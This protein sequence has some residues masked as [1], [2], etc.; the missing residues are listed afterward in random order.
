MDA[1]CPLDGRYLNKVEELRPYFSEMAL[2][3]ERLVVSVEYLNALSELPEIAELPPFSD[4]V[5]DRLQ[6][7]AHA[8]SADDFQRVRAIE[9]KVNHDVKAGEYFLREKITEH[10]LPIPLQFVRFGLTSEDDT[11]LAYGCLIHR[12]L[13]EVIRPNLG[14]ICQDVHD[15]TMQWED[16]PLLGMTHGQPAT[17]T[18]VGDQ[19]MVFADRL[20]RSAILLCEFSMDGKLGGAVGNLAAHKVAYPEVDWEKFRQD[21]VKSLALNPLTHTTQINS[22]DDLARLSHLM[23]EINTILLDMARDM[24]LYIMRGV[25]C[26]RVKAGEVGSSVM[27][28]KVNPLDWENAEG[29][30]GI[31]NALFSH[32]AEKLPISR[33]Q[34]DL[35]DSTVQRWLGCAFGAHLLAVK[36]IQKGLSKLQVNERKIQQ[37]LRENP[38]IHSEAIQTVMRRYG[39]IDAYEHLKALTR[40]KEVTAAD[41]KQFVQTLEHVPADAKQRLIK[42]IG[43]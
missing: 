2:V 28:H 36:S 24:W 11:N 30:L 8:F 41:L 3:R 15:F 43:E 23:I 42:A 17:A 33:M 21:F 34:R 5:V 31:A 32:F 20:T 40:G 16:L 38:A 37:E 4:D 39:Y 10:N 27:P 35:S 7:I 22:H 14:K 25:F 13:E 12:A 6:H 19:F 18:T 26:E 9:K 1:L 29:N